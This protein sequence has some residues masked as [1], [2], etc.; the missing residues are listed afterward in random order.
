M[1]AAVGFSI[2]DLGIVGLG[3][4]LGGKEEAGRGVVEMEV[5]GM[6]LVEDV[7]KIVAWRGEKSAGTGSSFRHLQHPS[8]DTRRRG[9]R[10]CR[11]TL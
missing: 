2:V 4:G 3:E 8:L 5:A 9:Q 1:V 10:G 7:V 11:Q 6:V